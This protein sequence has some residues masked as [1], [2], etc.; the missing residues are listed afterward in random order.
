MAR[1]I[2]YNEETDLYN[3]FSNVVDGFFLGKRS[4][5]CSAREMVC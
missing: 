3:I 4:Y 5:I 1:I 2:V